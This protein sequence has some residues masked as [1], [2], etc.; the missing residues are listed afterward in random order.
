[1]NHVEVQQTAIDHYNLGANYCRT[2][3]AKLQKEPLELLQ[4]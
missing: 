3:Y 4:E 1:M 2:F